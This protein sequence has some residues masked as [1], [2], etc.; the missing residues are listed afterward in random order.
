MSFFSRLFGKRALGLQARR[1][2]E[3]IYVAD[4]TGLADPR[5]RIVGGQGSPRDNFAILR[6]LAQFAGREEIALQAVFTGRP[7]REAGE[8]GRVREDRGERKGR[9]GEKEKE[10]N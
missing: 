1:A 4:A 5:A 7:L 6:M 3:R 9:G 2:Q 8:G 10:K